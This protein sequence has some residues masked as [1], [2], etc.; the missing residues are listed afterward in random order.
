MGGIED[1]RL[2]MLSV[3]KALFGDAQKQRRRRARESIE[4]WTVGSEEERDR[5]VRWQTKL[6]IVDTAEAL[7]KAATYHS[8]TKTQLHETIHSIIAHVT[9]WPAAG[10]QELVLKDAQELSATFV[11]SSEHIDDG[12]FKSFL[13]VTP[14]PSLQYSRSVLALL[15]TPMTLSRMALMRKEKKRS[16]QRS[17]RLTR[18]SCSTHSSPP[19]LRVQEG[20]WKKKPSPSRRTWSTW[21]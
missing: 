19:M 14:S 18:L 1:T 15:W 3:E 8:L 17:V 9:D 6:S 2:Y 4:A 16:P 10:Q 5:A 13:V 11:G 20:S 21:H 7:S 12:I